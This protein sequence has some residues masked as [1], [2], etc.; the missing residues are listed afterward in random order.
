[1]RCHKYKKSQKHLG[2][3]YSCHNLL[4]LVSA[5]KVFGVVFLYYLTVIQFNEI[6]AL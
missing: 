3:P 1:M 5:F 2:G 6:T 4:L